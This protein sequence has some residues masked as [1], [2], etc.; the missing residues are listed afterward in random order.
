M[1][2]ALTIERV[3]LLILGVFF[4]SNVIVGLLRPDWYLWPLFVIM[5]AC[6]VVW[7]TVVALDYESHQ[8]N[9][10]Q[11]YYWRY[12]YFGALPVLSVLAYTVFV[13]A[14]RDSEVLKYF[15]VSV[16]FFWLFGLLANAIIAVSAVVTGVVALGSFIS[17]LKLRRQNQELNC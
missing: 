15:L 11:L 8:Y 4:F 12:S 16:V 10:L 14:W 17:D 3:A 5:S 9:F 6:I 7:F 1:P 13:P 2:D